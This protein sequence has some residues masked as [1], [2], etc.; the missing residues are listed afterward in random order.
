MKK[1]NYLPFD[2]ENDIVDTDDLECCSIDCL[3]L[4]Y[5]W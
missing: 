3:C 2:G 5:V 4:A 1:Q